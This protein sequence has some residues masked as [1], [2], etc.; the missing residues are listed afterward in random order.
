[1]RL[2]PSGAAANLGGMTLLTVLAALFLPT[3]LTVL[4]AV[5]ALTGRCWRLPVVG[6]GG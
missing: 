1:M 3:M 6:P 2:D 5:G 4:C